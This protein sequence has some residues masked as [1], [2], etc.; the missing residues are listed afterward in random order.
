MNRNEFL[1]RARRY[2]RNN[3]LDYYF[4]PQQG[5]GS[6]GAVYVGG[7]RTFVPEGE[8]RPGTLFS[9]LKELGIDPRRF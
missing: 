9:I 1:R 7:V 4:N 5:K 6:H 8:I 3:E 2:A